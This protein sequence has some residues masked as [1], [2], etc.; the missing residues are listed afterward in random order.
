MYMLVSNTSTLVLLAKIGLL[1]KFLDSVSPITIPSQVKIEYSFDKTSYYARLLE[2]L[3]SDK[4]IIV[5]EVSESELKIV[6]QNFRLDKGEA[7]VYRL[8]KR[9]GYKAIL[10]DDGELIKLC[11]LDGIPFL[12]SLAIVIRLYEKKIITKEE[13]AEKLEMLNIIGR[14]SKEIYEYF[15]TE[16]R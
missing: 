2:N 14:Y 15:K 10:T 1:E 9:G 6:L 11:K 5:K 16:V 8:Y 7:A 13:A 3:A 4:K 12:C